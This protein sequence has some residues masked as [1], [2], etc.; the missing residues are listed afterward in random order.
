MAFLY[1]CKIAG[2]FMR[3]EQSFPLFKDILRTTV[4]LAYSTTAGG[5]NGA[6]EWD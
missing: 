6:G 3:T 5:A 1:E 2:F 4:F